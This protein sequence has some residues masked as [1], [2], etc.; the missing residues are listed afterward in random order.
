MAGLKGKTHINSILGNYNRTREIFNKS[1]N[2]ENTLEVIKSVIEV[3]KDCLCRMGAGNVSSKLRCNACTELGRLI[4]FDRHIVGNKSK[5]QLECGFNKGHSLIVSAESFPNFE[6][7]WGE[8]NRKLVEKLNVIHSN[9]SECGLNGPGVAQRYLVGGNWIN[10]LLVSWIIEDIFDNDPTSVG[11]RRKNLN[12]FQHAF[13]CHDIGY[14][15][16][17]DLNAVP[18]M[19]F[20]GNVLTVDNAKY[21]LQSLGQILRCLKKYQFVHGCATI[22]KLKVINKPDPNV[23]GSSFTI[24]LDG[25]HLSSITVSAENGSV[26]ILPSVKGRDVDLKSAIQ[27]FQPLVNT[28]KIAPPSRLC[29]GVIQGRDDILSPC[30]EEDVSDMIFTTGGS[31]ATLFTTMRYSGYPLFGGSFDMYSFFVSLMSWKPFGDLIASSK[32]ERLKNI[33]VEMFPDGTTGPAGPPIV[34]TDSTITCSYVV[35]NVLKDKWMYCNG[36]EKL[37]SLLERTV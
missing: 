37:L 15:L 20:F 12:V 10:E 23:P 19:D 11:G 34:R 1:L 36:C 27:N 29:R 6:V 33:W 17:Y 25:L 22:D 2:D 18:L 8:E 13:V 32:G 24:L 7:E 3:D 16:Y 14:K 21:I 35:S 30:G 31:K 26:R 5:I 9:L 4:N 28:Y